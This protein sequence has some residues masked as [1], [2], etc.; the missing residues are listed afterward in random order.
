MLQL[1]NGSLENT[2]HQYHR[3]N[4]NVSFLVKSAV[5]ALSIAVVTLTM[6]EGHL[7]QKEHLFRFLEFAGGGMAFGGLY[8]ITQHFFKEPMHWQ[9]TLG[10][11]IVI[12]LLAGGLLWMAFTHNSSANVLTALTGLGLAATITLVTELVARW[13]WKLGAFQPEPLIVISHDLPPPTP[14]IIQ[15][16]PQNVAPPLELEEEEG[17]E[18][19]QVEPQHEPFG[20]WQRCAY[21]PHL[22]WGREILAYEYQTPPASAQILQNKA[23]SSFMF[24]ITPSEERAI[25]EHIKAGRCF[26]HYQ[27]KHGDYW[28]YSKKYKTIPGGYV[29]AISFTAVSQDYETFQYGKKTVC[30]PLGEK[31]PEFLAIRG[32]SGSRTEKW[33]ETQLKREP[34]A[35]GHYY[36]YHAKSGIWFYSKDPFKVPGGCQSVELRQLMHGLP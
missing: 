1:T 10:T 27:D 17:Q 19:D 13:K 36:H 5:L 21:I 26:F 4:D 24:R 12:S 33:D 30:V 31:P 15:R 20:P 9:T 2:A 11:A 29:K 32:A 23:N 16:P 3:Q 14:V 7:F 8:L 34:F 22:M 25:K 28:L 18:I 6:F 35:V